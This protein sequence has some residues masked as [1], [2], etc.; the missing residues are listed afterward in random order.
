M[1]SEKKMY[2]DQKESLSQTLFS[3]F[4]SIDFYAVAPKLIYSFGSEN[5]SDSDERKEGEWKNI[6]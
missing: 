6:E 5:N 2:Y 4:Y 3:L 1:S